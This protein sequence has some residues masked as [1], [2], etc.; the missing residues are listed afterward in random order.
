MKKICITLSLAAALFFTACSGESEK[1]ALSGG[2]NLS[3]V[4]VNK[5]LDAAGKADQM[6]SA[7]NAVLRKLVSIKDDKEA[8]L[9]LDKF[10]EDNSTD[11]TAITVEFG[12]WSETAKEEELMAYIQN[13]Q[14]KEYFTELDSNLSII[15]VRMTQSPELEKSME[16]LMKLINPPS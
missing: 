14:T 6:M 4:S 3:E 15:G 11:L 16:T 8:A 1:L 7:V 2:I 5:S 10:I 12:K 9:T 13:L